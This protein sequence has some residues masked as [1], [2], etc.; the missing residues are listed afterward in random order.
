MRDL[1]LR[2][3]ALDTCVVDVDPHERFVA[4]KDFG[5]DDAVSRRGVDDPPKQL[6]ITDRV[7]DESQAD[8]DVDVE[9]F[10]LQD[11][12]HVAR[13]EFVLIRGDAV[14]GERLVG[15]L[16]ELR[17]RLDTGYVRRA[18]LER[19]EGPALSLIH[20]SEPTRPY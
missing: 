2:G 17:T 6:A 7:V 10:L 11:L 12:E 3:V 20:I 1:V 8:N 19:G 18:C 9:L 14:L 13:D 5:V 16:D 15:V 4:L